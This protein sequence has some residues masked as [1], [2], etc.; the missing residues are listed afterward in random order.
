[1]F[2]LEAL[3]HQWKRQWRSVTQVRSVLSSLLLLLVAVYFGLLFVG[4]GWVYPQIVVEVAP[5]QDPLRLLNAGL[6]YGAVGLLVARFF[7]QRSAGSAVRP[8]LALPLRRGQL[9]RT[10]QVTSALSLFNV[11]PLVLLAALWTSTVWPKASPLGAA[12]WGIGV[13]LLVILTQSANSLLRAAW[14]RSAA[15][16]VGAS[17]I[18]AAATTGGELIGF[19][20]LTAASA[21]L[22]GG[23]RAGHLLLLAGLGCAT[24]VTVLAA[25]WALRTRLY[26]VWTNTHTEAAV[27]PSVPEL[28]GIEIQGRTAS[29][30]LL[31]VKLILRNKR[32]RQMLGVAMPLNLGFLAFLAGQGTVDPYFELLFSFVLSG[33]LALPYFQFGYAWHGRHFDALLIHTESSHTLVR[34]HFAL[35]AGLCLCSIF[36]ILPVVI[37]LVPGILDALAALFLYN[38]GVCGPFFLLLG[39]WNRSA[40][41]LNQTTFFNY[42]GSSSLQAL[43][44]A[45]LMGLP[46]G[47]FFGMGP[48][49]T[50]WTLT[51]LGTLGLSTAPLW[52]SGLGWLLRRQRHA[53]A[54]GFRAT[55]P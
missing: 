4:G 15:R 7:L 53:M 18:L 24:G 49:P 39:T 46:L 34:A 52:M 36:A 43:S 22:F 25:H 21:Q 19:W 33:F 51:G 5:N 10:L 40:L 47:L 12:C 50:L 29:L 31:G 13:L 1:M 41:A 6:L 45:V 8:Y 55:D 28:E 3:E 44:I 48:Q 17:A 14:D 9:V 16:V 38:L 2:V 27:A 32:P 23:L 35:F 37:W 26:A 11:L 20:S 30:V 54:A 42:Q